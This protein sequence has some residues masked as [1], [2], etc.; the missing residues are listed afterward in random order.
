MKSRNVE[1]AEI[2]RLVRFHDD[3]NIKDI[4][5]DVRVDLKFLSFRS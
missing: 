1:A 5:F 4:C 3:E 2:Y